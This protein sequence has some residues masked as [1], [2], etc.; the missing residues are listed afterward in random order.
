MQ[1]R[2]TELRTLGFK[3][4]LELTWDQLTPILVDL[5]TEQYQRTQAKEPIVRPGWSEMIA[6]V[7]EQAAI[8]DLERRMKE[9][10][11]PSQRP[12]NPQPMGSAPLKTAEDG[13]VAWD[14]MWTDFCDLA[15]AGGPSHRGTL[16]EAVAAEE[17]RADLERYQ[18]VV[19]EISRGISMVTALPIKDSSA[20]GWVGV[21]CDSQEMAL[22]LVRAII[23]ENVMVRREENVIYLPAGPKFSIQGEIKN[24]I[25]VVAKTVHYWS[26]HRSAQEALLQQQ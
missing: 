23:V 16:L 21:E 24:V 15:M 7:D 11:P 14:Q 26:A 8:A 12:A 25:T 6:V 4:P 13:E 20:L 18:A 2:R 17:C 9:I 22:W 19:A 10:L 1:L 3:E 5:L